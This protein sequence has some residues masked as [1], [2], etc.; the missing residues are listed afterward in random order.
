LEPEQSTSTKQRIFHADVHGG[1]YKQ[2]LDQ[3]V[4]WIIIPEER[5]A[6]LGLSNDQE[7]DEFIRQFWV[8]RNPK[9]ASAK[10]KFK[11]EHYRRLA[12]ANTHFAAG[13]P[14]W[15][16]DRGHVYIVFGQPDSIDSHPAAGNRATKP[17]EIWHYRS[18]RVGWPTERESDANRRK[19]QTTIIKDFDFKFVDECVCGQY[20]LESPWPSAESGTL[21]SGS[22]PAHSPTA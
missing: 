11:E 7:R 3:D 18:I 14:G 12:F 13:E 9:P 5:Q 10:N 19:V 15:E 16:T 2:W 8:R 21:A 17:F 20:R 4:R 22:A 6:F 1:K